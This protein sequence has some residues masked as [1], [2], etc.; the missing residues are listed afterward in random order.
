MV[1]VLSSYTSSMVAVAWVSVIKRRKFLEIIENVSEVDNKIRYALQEE[2]YMNRKIMFNVISEIILLTLIKRTVIVYNTYQIANKP[3]YFIIIEKI[4]YVP[5]ICNALVLFQFGNLVLMLKQRYNHLRKH[6][7]F[8]IN[9]AVSRPICLN[10]QNERCSE[11]NRAF[12]QENITTLYVSSVRNIK[13]TLRLTDTHLLRQICS[14][15][16]DIT[17]LISDT[18]GIP[19]LASV[20]SVL[21][22]VV[23]CLYEVLI[24]FNM[25]AEKI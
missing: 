6:L 7:T 25:W 9:G 8:W 19:I 18:Y 3:Y 17:Y 13:G 5:D 16:Y 1:Y 11:C 10:K 21:T 15:L 4:I 20:C 23:F 22:C 2:T 12:D 14:E 24:I